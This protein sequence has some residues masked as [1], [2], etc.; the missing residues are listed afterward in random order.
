MMSFIIRSTAFSP[1]LT[2]ALLYILTRGPASLRNPLLNRLRTPSDA[3]RLTSILKWLFAFGLVAQLNQ[4]LSRWAAN[5]WI[6]RETPNQWQ[7]RKEV[8][9]VTGGS[10][11]I[12]ALITRGL[13]KKGLKV[14]VLD[15]Q[16]L[17][18]DLQDCM[19]RAWGCRPAACR[20]QQ[21]L[22]ILVLSYR[23]QCVILSM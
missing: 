20:D 2:G 14:V 1:A 19:S 15:I 21:E 8:A 16:P 12:G 11:G 5:S 17:P 22:I 4:W 3:A 6:W 23:R 7:W 9:V 10:S 18:A 13:S